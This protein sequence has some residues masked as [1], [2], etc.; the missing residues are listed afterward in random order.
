MPNAISFVLKRHK[1]CVTVVVWEIFGRTAGV[2]VMVGG[3]GD[4]VSHAP[5][6]GGSKDLTFDLEL[7]LPCPS[8]NSNLDGSTLQFRFG[9]EAPCQD[10]KLQL[11]IW[12]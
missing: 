10:R 7:G 1:F 8:S 5:W 3:D 9:P 12:S 2:G 4:A 11:L 6:F